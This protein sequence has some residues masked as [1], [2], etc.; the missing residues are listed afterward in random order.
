MCVCVCVCVCVFAFEKII[1]VYVRG[2]AFGTLLRSILKENLHLQK[3]IP[4]FV[5]C[6]MYDRF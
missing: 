1:F 4:V 2:Q 6:V 3:T 5:S